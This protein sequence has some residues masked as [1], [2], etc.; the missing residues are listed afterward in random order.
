MN[1]TIF[2]RKCVD[3]NCHVGEQST[4]YSISSVPRGRRNIDNAASVSTHSTVDLIN[5]F[6]N[7]Y[8]QHINTRIFPETNK[9]YQTHNFRSTTQLL[10][11]FTHANR[12]VEFSGLFSG[13]EILATKLESMEVD[14]FR[15]YPAREPPLLPHWNCC[16]IRFRCSSSSFSSHPKNIVES[17]IYRAAL[18]FY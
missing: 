8:V 11:M 4:W 14:R 7:M 13:C 16:L 3:C 17:K 6:W 10:I 9:I 1:K 15:S 2:D 12:S 18:L 5:Y